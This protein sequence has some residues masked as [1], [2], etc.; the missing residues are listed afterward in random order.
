MKITLKC[1]YLE[2]FSTNDI[3]DLLKQAKKRKEDK[4]QDQVNDNLTENTS[5][6]ILIH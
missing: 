2:S 6:I 4:L 5:D 3:R 1:P